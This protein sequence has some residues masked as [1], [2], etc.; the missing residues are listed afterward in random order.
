MQLNPFARLWKFN[1]LH[2]VS[3]YLWG[4][5]H[6]LL[7]ARWNPTHTFTFYSRFASLGAFVDGILFSK[8]GIHF[9]CLLVISQNTFELTYPSKTTLAENVCHHNLSVTPS[10]VCGE[11]LGCCGYE[12][13][14]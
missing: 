11:N 14:G 4:S 2:S 13:D 8:Q 6:V 10:H 3:H 12:E 1:S 5:A 9:E 7:R